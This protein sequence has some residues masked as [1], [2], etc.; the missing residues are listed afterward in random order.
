MDN[1]TSMIVRNRIKAALLKWLFNYLAEI[2]AQKSVQ[3]WVPPKALLRAVAQELLCS[4]GCST[5]YVAYAGAY[6]TSIQNK[7]P[8]MLQLR[9]HLQASQLGK[10][11]HL[12]KGDNEADKVLVGSSLLLS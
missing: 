3:N 9:M 5:I 1:Y 11:V 10:R 7:E 8:P 12:E 4:S 6:L 2:A